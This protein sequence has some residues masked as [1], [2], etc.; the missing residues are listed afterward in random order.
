MAVFSNLSPGEYT[1]L[2]KYR[3]NIT[4]KESEPYSLLIRIT[5]PWYMT[6]CAYIVYFLL[7]AGVIA[8][9]IQMVIKRY[10]RK[11]NV[12]IEEMNRQQREELYA[13]TDFT[14][15]RN[16]VS[17]LTLPMNFVLR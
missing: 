16:C 15:D 11:R 2:V 9:A 4:G 12:M 14:D 5:P 17:L 10:R 13:K 6:T 1:L 8:G 3:S 7:L